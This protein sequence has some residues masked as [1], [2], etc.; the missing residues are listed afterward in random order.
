MS[1]L[2]FELFHIVRVLCDKGQKRATFELKS[3]IRD[4]ESIT[5]LKEFPVPELNR[6]HDGNE[7][8]D[9]DG[10]NPAEA[11]AG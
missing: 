2:Y 3:S 10:G 7:G 11:I 1:N 8:R 5:D 6:Q 9:T 4:S